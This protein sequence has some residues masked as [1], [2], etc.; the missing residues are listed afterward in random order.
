MDTTLMEHVT[1][2][3]PEPEKATPGCHPIPTYVKWKTTRAYLNEHFFLN[4]PASTSGED[5]K[6]MR[7]RSF[8]SSCKDGNKF[9]GPQTQVQRHQ[10]LI[11]KQNGVIITNITVHFYED[12]S[13]ICGN[14][15]WYNLSAHNDISAPPVILRAK[16]TPP[17]NERIFKE[18]RPNNMSN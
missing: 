12:E 3:I 18:I 10:T 11:I 6:V 17:V 15:K 13:C 7:C 8:L 4:I 2:R 5:L 9:C 16:Y 14:E 1:P